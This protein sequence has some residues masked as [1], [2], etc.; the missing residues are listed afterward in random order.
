M[1]SPLTSLVERAKK[2]DEGALSALLTKIEP[3]LR[4]FFIARIGRR[5]DVDDLVQNTLLRVHRGL[6]DLK[7]NARLKA[8]AMKGALYELQDFYR[9]RYTPKEA[10]FD[11]HEPPDVL[12]ND[13]DPEDK[14]DVEQ[15]LSSLSPKAREII[16]LR[17]YGYK[18]EEIAEMVGSTEAAIKMQV[19]RA[20][21]KMKDTLSTLL[22]WIS[23]PLLF[24]R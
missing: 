6:P 3:A 22:V 18:Y 1:S 17:E 2:G 23:V 12:S 16:E 5:I 11:A 14:M 9:G 20:F 24:S 21:E 7:D 13:A 8:F 15:A 4:S 10:L 19:K